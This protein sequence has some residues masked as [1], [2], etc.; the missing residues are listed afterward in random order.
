MGCLKTA[1]LD[2]VDEVGRYDGASWAGEGSWLGMGSREQTQHDEENGKLGQ[3]GCCWY[4][5]HL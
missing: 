5:S 4:L 1:G 3:I 2:R